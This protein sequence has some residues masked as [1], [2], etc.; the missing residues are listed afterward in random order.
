MLSW[1]PIIAT[2]TTLERRAV[3][4]LVARSGELTAWE[5]GFIAKLATHGHWRLS[6]TQTLKLAEIA[7]KYL[8]PTWSAAADEQ[9]AVRRETLVGVV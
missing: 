1:F 4:M 6:V 7:G 9:Q 3:R 2:M 8:P 5:R